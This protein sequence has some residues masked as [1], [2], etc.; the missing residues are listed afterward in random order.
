MDATSLCLKA[1]EKPTGAQAPQGFLPEFQRHLNLFPHDTEWLLQLE[2][3]SYGVVTC[4]EESC[5]QDFPLQADPLKRDGGASVGFGSLSAFHVHINTNAAHQQARDARVARTASMQKNTPAKRN[6]PAAAAAAAIMERNASVDRQQPGSVDKKSKFDKYGRLVAANGTPPD[7][8]PAPQKRAKLDPEPNVFADRANA[9]AG[10]APRDDPIPAKKDDADFD[11]RIKDYEAQLAQLRTA[12]PPWP[13]EHFVA[14]DAVQRNIDIVKA[15]KVEAQRI[16]FGGAPRPQVGAAGPLPQANGYPPYN[17]GAAAQDRVAQQQAALLQAG[18]GGAGNADDSDSDHEDPIGR[19][20]ANARLAND[21]DLHDLLRAAAEGES[22]EGNGTVDEAAAK[23][24][25]KKQTDFIDGMK[26]PLMAHQLMGVAWMYEQENSKNYGGILGDEMGL[27]KTIQTIA[28]MCKNMSN[29]PAEKT[30]LIIAPVALLEQWKDEIEDKCEKNQFK[31]L[32]YHGEG[33]KNVTKIKH[34]QKYD[35]VLTS[36]HT[37]AMEWPDEETAVKKAKKQAKKQG[38][39]VDEDDFIQL[40]SQGILLGMGWYRVILDEA[41]N[42]RNRSTKISRAVAQLDSLFRWCLTGTPVTNSLS[43]IFPLLRF[44]QIKPFYDWPSYREQVVFHEKKNPAVAGRKAQAILRGCMMRRKKDTQL[45]G[46][47]LVTLPQKTIELRELEFSQEERDIYSFIE[48][49][50]QAV[51][52]K[53]LKA[54]TVLKNYAHV[55]VML[56]RLRQVCFHPCLIAEGYEA[57]AADNKKEHENAAE[58]QRAVDVLKQKAVDKIREQRLELAVERCKVEK[59]GNDAQFDGDDC[60]ICM[61]PVSE[62]EKGGIV[63]GCQHV[64]CR[65]CIDEVLAKDQVEDHD[66]D[67]KA[68]KYKA[69][70]RPCPSCRQPISKTLT[71]S[72][73]AFEPTDDEL[74]EATGI[75]MDVDEDIDDDGD[76]KNFI[77]KDDEMDEDDED[78]KPSSSKKVKQPNRRIIQDSDDESEAEEEKPSKQDKGKGKEKAGPVE[79]PSWMEKQE[80][81]TKMKWALAE[82][83]RLDAEFPDDKIIIISSFTTALDLMADML[84][85]ADF[86]VTRYQGDMTRKER[87]DSVR[88]LK[89]S[90]K[91]KIMLMS[92]KCGGVGLNLTRANRVISL[93]LAW[94]NAVESQAFDRTHRIG[95]LKEVQIDRLT[96]SNTVEQR[97]GEMQTRKQGLADAAFG[98]GGGAK[99][100]KL[101]VAEL[102]GL[103]GITINARNDNQ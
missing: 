39:D 64:F 8:L 88:V 52:N 90:K 63:T 15:E 96:I 26:I 43:D 22:F 54:G 40:K 4:M 86:K 51:F 10:P 103:F 18:F 80:P 55:L 19:Y 89:K 6:T 74:S 101:S 62:D 7:D 82:V 97:I 75:P 72:L 41:Q 38:D 92:L 36:Y 87:D 23:L 27:G 34:L 99:I 57:L 14:L 46:K 37:L 24:G 29:D 5:Y 53:Y 45:D 59:E 67:P 56:L 71:F 69:D 50:S 28:T 95:Q 13:P 17:Y 11:R 65:T 49:R 77:A 94:S 73:S 100:G 84:Y 25:L 32:V 98:E 79:L 48:G 68:I 91:C 33:K 47:E 9:I 81:S 44:L 20:G 1:L 3:G 76:L 35:V 85:E 70:Q 58:L 102:A 2:P 42:I 12:R 61:T 21:E 83:Q 30:N 93:D 60:P 66:D 78:D 16:R 31:I